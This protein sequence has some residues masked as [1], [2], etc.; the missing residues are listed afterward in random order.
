MGIVINSADTAVAARTADR[1]RERNNMVM[2]RDWYMWGIAG[3]LLVCIQIQYFFVVRVGV[4][5]GLFVLFVFDTKRE[6]NEGPN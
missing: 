3:L 4:C 5:S 6:M 1:A 2:R